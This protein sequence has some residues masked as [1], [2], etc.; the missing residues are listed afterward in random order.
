MKSWENYSEK[1]QIKKFII[2]ILLIII[3]LMLPMGTTSADYVED[4]SELGDQII[5]F[6]ESTDENI[7]IV[8]GSFCSNLEYITLEYLKT[9]FDIIV[10]KPVLIDTDLL[11]NET[12]NKTLVLIGGPKQN[13]ITK[14]LLDYQ[15]YYIN[16]INISIGVFTGIISFVI[17]RMEK[18]R[19]YFLILQDIITHLELQPAN[20][21]WSIS[22]L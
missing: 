21:P 1:K 12:I 9:K 17:M 2:S 13:S 18:K 16:Q 6:L 22:F 4:L 10:G 3:T 7:I 19:L 14:E 11:L 20:L 15:G 8:E 5:E